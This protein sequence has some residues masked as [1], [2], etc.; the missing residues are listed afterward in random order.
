[1]ALLHCTFAE[2]EVV[3]G[4]KVRMVGQGSGGC[5]AREEV[6]ILLVG[7][8]SGALSALMDS[9]GGGIEFEKCA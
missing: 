4:Y 1:M 6:R 7:D 3:W 9:V 5:R 2:G 8:R